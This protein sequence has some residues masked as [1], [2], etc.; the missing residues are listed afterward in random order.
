MLSMFSEVNFS[1]LDREVMGVVDSNGCEPQELFLFSTREKNYKK[2]EFVGGLAFWRIGGGNAVEVDQTLQRV[3]SSSEVSKQLIGRLYHTLL[4]IF[5]FVFLSQSLQVDRYYVQI[6]KVNH[7]SLNTQSSKHPRHMNLTRA[8]TTA[9]MFSEQ[10]I[11][12]QFALVLKK[13][14]T[15]KIN[16]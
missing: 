11:Q 15:L 16:C 8:Q 5:S 12:Q 3:N 2:L 14:K 4:F 13:I 1:G 7:V 6:I 9:L 10:V